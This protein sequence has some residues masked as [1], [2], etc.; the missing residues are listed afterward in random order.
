MK[1]TYKFIFAIILSLFITMIGISLNS[2][3][4]SSD[5][6]EREDSSIYIE[7]RD[8]FSVDGH[9]IEYNEDFARKSDGLIGNW[10]LTHHWMSHDHIT[11]T[12]YNM[13]KENP[14]RG[15]REDSNDVCFEYKKN[16]KDINYPYL[17]AFYRNQ[18]AQEEIGLTDGETYYSLNQEYVYYLYRYSADVT[19]IF[20]DR[21]DPIKHTSGLYPYTEREIRV[22][23]YVRY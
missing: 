1:K 19:F 4:K 20:K 5:I 14:D 6:D 18:S 2:C 9:L 22:E 3:S 8:I 23:R 13:Y 16:E 11:Q 10:K 21:T 7:A 12:E 15:W 17:M